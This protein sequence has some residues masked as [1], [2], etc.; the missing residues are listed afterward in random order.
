MAESPQFS[1]KKQRI[2]GWLL[3]RADNH[4][5]N[6]QLLITGAAVFFIGASFIIWADQSLVSSVRQELIALIGLIMCA[7]GCLTALLGYLGLSILRLLRFFND[8]M[9]K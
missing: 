7:A 8:N 3:A 9:D 5:N 1:K 6:L 4:K 2:T